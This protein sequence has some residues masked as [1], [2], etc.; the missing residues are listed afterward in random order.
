MEE[1]LAFCWQ[2]RQKSMRLVGFDVE[3]IFS[4]ETKTLCSFPTSERLGNPA[5]FLSLF[6]NALQLIEF[7]FELFEHFLWIGRSFWNILGG[8]IVDFPTNPYT[9]ADREFLIVATIVWK[10]VGRSV[11]FWTL[12][13]LHKAKEPLVFKKRDVHGRRIPIG[14]TRTT[15]AF[16]LSTHGSDL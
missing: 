4:L 11:D 3:V 9:R 2:S 1:P 12:W 15:Q 8:R 5:C 13:L 14:S 10:V 6:P 16:K 7:R